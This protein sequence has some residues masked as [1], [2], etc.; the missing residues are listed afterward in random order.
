MPSSPPRQ[1]VE[2]EREYSF[3]AGQLDPQRSREEEE[4]GERG[5]LFSVGETDSNGGGREEEREGDGVEESPSD[6]DELRQRRLQR[7][8]SLPAVSQVAAGD[9]AG[10]V[11]DEKTETTSTKE[12]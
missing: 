10:V 9:S 4:D 5:G 6:M 8:H 3:S 7:F 12:Q 1:L 11:A 2:G